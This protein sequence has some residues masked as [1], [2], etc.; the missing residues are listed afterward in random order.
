MLETLSTGEKDALF[1][2]RYRVSLDPSSIHPDLLLEGQA[3]HVP[4]S[5]GTRNTLFSDDNV[6]TTNEISSEMWH[7]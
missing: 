4:Q 5:S 7:M 1:I 6:H 2:K 3:C